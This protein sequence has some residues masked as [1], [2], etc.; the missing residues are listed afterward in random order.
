MRN[1]SCSIVTF[2][3]ERKGKLVP[4]LIAL[5]NRHARRSRPLAGGW[6]G[7]IRARWASITV[8]V[9]LRTGALA[10]GLRR[11][12]GANFP[13]RRAKVRH[14]CIRFRSVV[15]MGVICVEVRSAFRYLIHPAE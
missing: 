1:K 14:S 3:T 15:D 5:G 2:Q 4:R 8:N 9:K 7:S 11:D 6:P 13:Q 10:A 12:L